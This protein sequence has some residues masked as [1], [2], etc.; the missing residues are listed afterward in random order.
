MTPA[1]RTTGIPGAGA[2]IARSMAVS[3]F[4][5]VWAGFFAMSEAASSIHQDMSEAYVWGQEFRLGYNQHPPFWAWI[6]GAWFEIMPRAGWS[7]AILAAVNAALGLWGSW[8]LI[9]RFAKGDERV[10]ATA[11]L[12]LTPFYTFFAREI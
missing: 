7:F 5:L 12:V 4:A 10:A 11:L 8:R 2:T 3:A 9:G 1:T 6:C